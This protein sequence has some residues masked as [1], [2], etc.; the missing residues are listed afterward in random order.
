MSAADTGFFVMFLLLLGAL[1]ASNFIQ[2][3]SNEKL[4]FQ[5]YFG[6]IYLIAMITL[7]ITGWNSFR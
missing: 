6:L 2:A 3:R 1:S 5:N 7:L 4:N